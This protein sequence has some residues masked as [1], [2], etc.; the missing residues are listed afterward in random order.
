LEQNSKLEQ[1]LS[2][3]ALC[4]APDRIRSGREIEFTSLI[5]GCRIRMSSI[6]HLVGGKCNSTGVSA[7]EAVLVW[8]PWF[9]A[10]A[11]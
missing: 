9:P 8:K 6:A 10:T 1:K 5:C 7:A 4:G 2:A 11:T 3:P